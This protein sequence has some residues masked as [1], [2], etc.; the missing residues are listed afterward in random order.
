MRKKTKEENP[1][2]T[3]IF[4]IVGI[5]LGLSGVYYIINDQGL[6]DILMG[7]ALVI[8]GFIGGILGFLQYSQ[9]KKSSKN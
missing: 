9:N 4:S 2:V 6:Y 8:T 1:T 3:I 5:L 7:T